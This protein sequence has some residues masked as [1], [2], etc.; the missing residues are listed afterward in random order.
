[1][2]RPTDTTPHDDRDAERCPCRPVLDVLSDRWSALVL[3]TLAD[4]PLRTG[5]LRR[6]LDGVSAKVLSATLKRLVAHV[7]VERTVLPD[8]PAHVEYAL[9]VLG[10]SALEPLHAVRVW[11]EAHGVPTSSSTGTAPTH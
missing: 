10:T 3:E 8:V 5:E 4:G 11:A 9:T 6:R 1:M 2:I 7:L